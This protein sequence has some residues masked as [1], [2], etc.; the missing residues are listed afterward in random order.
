MATPAQREAQI[1]RLRW[2]GWRRLW[3]GIP[4][5]STPGWDAG[6][7]FEHLLLRAFELDKAKVRYPYEVALLDEKVEEIDG[8]VHLPALSCLVESKDLGHNVDIAPSAKLRNQLLRRPGGTVGIVFSSR[9][10][11]PPAFLLAHFVLPQT[12]LLWQGN[13]VELVLKE[14]GICDLLRLAEFLEAN[15]GGPGWRYTISTATL[16]FGT[17]VEFEATWARM[18]TRIIPGC[19]PGTTRTSTCLP[20]TAGSPGR[21]ARSASARASRPSPPRTSSISSR[22]SARS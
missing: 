5:G 15:A 4:A 17:E 2:P 18:S 1:K 9:G 12:I 14:E 10:F 7:A 21:S 19:G 16:T 8:A 22:S 13:E 20:R 6:E 3:A 11:T